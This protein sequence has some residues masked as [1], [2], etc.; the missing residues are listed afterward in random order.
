MMEAQVRIA[1]L[2]CDRVVE[3]YPLP[4]PVSCHHAAF[5]RMLGGGLGEDED[6]RNEN[7]MKSFALCLGE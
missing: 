3:D 7:D 5:Y 6:S 4:Q 2:L 1:R